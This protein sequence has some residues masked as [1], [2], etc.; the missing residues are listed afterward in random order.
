MLGNGRMAACPP[1][2]RGRR[3]TRHCLFGCIRGRVAAGCFLGAMG[4]PSS[5]AIGG[6]TSSCSSYNISVC[7]WS[8]MGRR[9]LPETLRDAAFFRLGEST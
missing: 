4:I 6:M 9:L 8:M 3:S 7:R 2:T 5:R 1:G